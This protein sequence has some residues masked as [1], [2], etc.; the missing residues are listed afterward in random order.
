MQVVQ[1]GLIDLRRGSLE[2]GPGLCG[3]RESDDVAKAGS[4]DEQHCQAIEAKREPAMGRDTVPECLQQES[5]FGLRF[6]LANA[7]RTEYG[8]LKRLV[9]NPDRAAGH[10]HAVIHRIVRPGPQA[11]GVQFFG[12]SS[13][14]DALRLQKDAGIVGVRGCE[15]VMHGDEASR[16][17]VEIE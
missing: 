3:L 11:A 9:M 1:I 10:F 8:A 7:E 2:E 16:I 6:L 13:R 5:E 15:G 4:P 12:D 14:C 17:G